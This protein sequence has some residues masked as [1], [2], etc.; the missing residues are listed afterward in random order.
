LFLARTTSKAESDDNR[1]NNGHRTVQ[2]VN[3]PL[4]L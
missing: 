4:F 2:Y 1:K 3:H